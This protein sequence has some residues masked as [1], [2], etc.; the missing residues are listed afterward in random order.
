PLQLFEGNQCQ[1]MGASSSHSR[2]IVLSVTRRSRPY[3]L[4]SESEPSRPTCAAGGLMLFANRMYSTRVCCATVAAGSKRL[5]LSI[6][7][8]RRGST[9]RRVPT[10]E[11]ES[12]PARRLR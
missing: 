12:L 1:G 3:F 2:P 6:L 4:R 5:R 8:R 11:G 9:E 7:Y 10:R